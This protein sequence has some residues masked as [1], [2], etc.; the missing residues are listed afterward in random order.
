MSVSDNSD[1]LVS[2]VENILDEYDEGDFHDYWELSGKV[3]GELPVRRFYIHTGQA[4]HGH[5]SV[6]GRL[7]VGILTD[8]SVVDVEGYLSVRGYVHYAPSIESGSLDILPLKAIES[9]EFHEGPIQTL[10]E[11][12]NAKLVLIANILGRDDI[13]RYWIAETDDEYGCLVR[14]GAALMEAVMKL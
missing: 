11:S 4:D 5:S 6:P 3:T 1:A 13:G 10:H 12:S 7:N 9:I 2:I 14:F 8:N